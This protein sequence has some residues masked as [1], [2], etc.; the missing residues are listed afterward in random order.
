MDVLVIT[1]LPPL[2]LVVLQTSDDVS[3]RWLVAVHAFDDAHVELRL[4]NLRFC[5][6][7]CHLNTILPVLS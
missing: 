1:A 4:G 3:L 2:I 7:R 6:Y 5:I